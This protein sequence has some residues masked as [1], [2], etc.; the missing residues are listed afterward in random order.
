MTDAGWAER[1]G[2][3]PC[4]VCGEKSN[5]KFCSMGCALKFND[6]K[7]AKIALQ[8]GRGGKG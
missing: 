1:K 8:R 7:R 6:M 2:T 3:I 5:M 4:K